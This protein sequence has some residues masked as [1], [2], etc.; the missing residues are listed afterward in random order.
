M[1]YVIHGSDTEKA[2]KKLKAM[3]DI[4]QSKRPDATVFKI[5][6][7]SFS[8]SYIEESVSGLSLFVPKNIIILDSL[9][10]HKEHSDFIIDKIPDFASSDHVCIIFDKKL[11]K[12]HLKKLEKKAEKIEE[13]NLKEDGDAGKFKKRETSP[14]FPFGEAVLARDKVRSW[15]LFQT[16]MA[17]GV[18]PE[19][20]HGILWWQFKS[21][22][23]SYSYGAK[24]SGL[25]PFVHRKCMDAQ[26]RWAK[27]EVESLLHEMIQ[28]YHKSH[29]GELDFRAEL[30]QLCL[31]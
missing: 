4:L 6:P 5:T 21:L 15:T 24:E 8:E 20:I 3:T 31:K 12:E 2:R 26:K 11:T 1:L 19:E 14:V 13:H 9:I 30:E 29:K 18:A 28:M 25:N 7:E 27:E 10:T 22:Y 17:D 16:I 23:L